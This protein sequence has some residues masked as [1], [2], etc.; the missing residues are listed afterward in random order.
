M[1]TATTPEFGLVTWDSEGAEGG[2]FHSRVLSVPSDESGLTLGRGYDMKMRSAA[3]IIQD[4]TVSEV[5]LV[6][7][8]LISKAAGLSGAAAKKFITDNKLGKFEISKNGQKT[9][10]I[11][12]YLELKADVKRLCTKSDVVEKYGACNWDKLDSAIVDILVDLRFRGDYTGTARQLVQKAV[13]KNDLEAFAKAMLLA[14]NWTNVPADRFK[15][16][17]AFLTAALAARRAIRKPIP[18]V[19]DIVGAPL[20]FR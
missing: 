6:D 13:V 14:S 3:T 4:L 12:T 20:K 8:T 11:R 17:N 7:A 5:S 18:F 1:A 10:F 19:S 15:R 9:L 16:R 2:P